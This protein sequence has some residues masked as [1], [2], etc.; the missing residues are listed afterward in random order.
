MNLQSY[1]CRHLAY[2]LH[3]SEWHF[4]TLLAACIHSIEHLPDDADSVINKLLFAYPAKP[5]RQTI[6]EFL[7]ANA[8]VRN[9]FQFYKPKT[10]K[11]KITAYN[12]SLLKEPVLVNAHLPELHN[13]DDVAE[14]LGTTSTELDWL[15]DLWR[16]DESTA[17][18]LRHYH[19]SLVPKRHG[20]YRLIE[21]P[22]EILKQAQRE[23]NQNILNYL[24]VD[25][26]AHG[27]VK[28]KSCQT[29]AA[30]HTRKKYLIH[31]DLADCFQSIH[32]P[33][34][35]SLFRA[36]GY[37]K[38][39]AKYLT[40]LCTHR[41][42]TASDEIFKQLDVDFR[43]KL[44]QRHLP[45]GAP[46]SPALSNAVLIRLDKRL[47][48][49]ARSM[50]LTYSR[51]ADDFVFSG[52][53]PQNWQTFKALVGSICLDEGFELNYRKTRFTQSNQ[54]QKITGIVVNEKLN[55]D[56]RYYDRLKAILSNCIRDGI[57][58]QNLYDQPN[59]KAHLFGRIQYVKSLNKVKGDKL[60]LLF[61]R[62]T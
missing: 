15:A 34:I 54:R 28:G 17:L 5:Q 8:I 41:C 46:S 39:V 14:W 1:F 26:S 27:F 51:Y 3:D 40:G 53:E 49:L 10:H 7:I 47:S 62:I 50:D 9:W 2:W 52:N 56:R 55:I 22:K 13:A 42:Y 59:F 30:L 38:T 44:K 21:S 4:T 18:H 24:P 36:L 33:P 35:L 58:S 32:W 43:E 6:T 12:V 16:H 11:P 31:F 45:Q 23:I 37:S 48:G 20:N 25:Q 19:Y 60:A 61:D 57:E 29:H